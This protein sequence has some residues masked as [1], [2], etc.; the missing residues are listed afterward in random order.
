LL[1]GSFPYEILEKEVNAREIEAFKSRNS[2]AA[3]LCH[4]IGCIRAWTGFAT[5]EER[6]LHETSHKQ[7]FRCKEPGCFINFSSRQALRKHKREYHIKEGDW[8][9]PR[10]VEPELMN[11]A[12]VG[13]ATE[14]VKG[15]SPDYDKPWYRAPNPDIIAQRAIKLAAGTSKTELQGIV[16]RMGQAL[17]NK[18]KDELIEP[19]AYHFRKIAVKEFRVVQDESMKKSQV[20]GTPTGAERRLKLLIKNTVLQA[21]LEA[22]AEAEI[23]A[24]VDVVVDMILSRPTQDH[25]TSANWN[26]DVSHLWTN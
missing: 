16:E 1:D 7:Q 5:T 26:D 25:G 23:D 2:D 24:S 6:E 10:T 19:L 4:W 15:L 21:R 22:E 3:Y 18:L 12:T 9:L 13:I 17:E 11:G 14:S 20:D 8:V